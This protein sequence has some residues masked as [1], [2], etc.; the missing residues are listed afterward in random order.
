M[1]DRRDPR[2]MALVVELAESSQ[3]APSYEELGELV[4]EPIGSEPVR[5]LRRPEPVRRRS[6]WLAGVAAAVV[7]LISIGAVVWLIRGDGE[8]PPADEPAPPSLIGPGAWDLAVTLPADLFLTAD[9]PY[10][11]IDDIVTGLESIDGVVEVAVVQGSRDDWTNLLGAEGAGIGCSP[12]CEQGVVVV[13]ETIEGLEETA[14]VFFGFGWEVPSSEINLSPSAST[15]LAELGAARVEHL[16]SYIDAVAG[17]TGPE[18]MFD[19]D[20][21][22]TEQVLVAI[23]ASEVP[24]PGHPEPVEVF[25]PQALVVKITGT[26]VGAFLQ[27]PEPATLDSTDAIEFDLAPGGLSPDDLRFGLVGFC[28]CEVPASGE[29]GASG[30]S[31]PLFLLDPTEGLMSHELRSD[32]YWRIFSERGFAFGIA[33]LPSTVA[34]VATELSDGTR[35]WQR[36]VSGIAF[37]TA[38]GSFE[39]PF[40]EAGGAPSLVGYDAAGNQIFVRR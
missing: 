28:G 33:G 21:L 40:A 30:I 18:P 34:V 4:V 7:V 25:R 20:G 11:S 39:F 10:E 2:I 16:T 19:T 9:F 38:N 31:I 35:L 37:F 17:Q 26:G 12:Q 29:L 8:V 36:P 3:S 6:G 14:R 32:I 15:R 13:A 27:Y 22:G 5:P 1:T 23:D 24:P